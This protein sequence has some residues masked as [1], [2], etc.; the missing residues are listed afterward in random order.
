MTGGYTVTGAPGVEPV[1][2]AQIKTWLNISV[3]TYDAQLAILIKAAR[4]EVEKRTGRA[5]ITQTITLYLDGFPTGDI[6]LPKPP[7]QSV[8]S[9][10]YYDGDGVQQTVDTGDYIVDTSKQPGRVGLAAGAYWPSTQ[11]RAKAVEIIYIAGY[12]DAST[13]VPGMLQLACYWLLGTMQDYPT[14]DV[15]N[16]SLASVPSTSID[17]LLALFVV[18]PYFPGLGD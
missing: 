5:L 13:N 16:V 17:R 18:D 6:S 10:K 3:S 4:E 2:A 1:T 12:G 11:L 7:L 15:P 9:V 8:T 14:L